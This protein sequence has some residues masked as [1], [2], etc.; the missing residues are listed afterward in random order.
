MERINGMQR[1]LS[2]IE[3]NLC[4]EIDYAKAAALAQTKEYHFQ[5]LFSML[6]GMTLG[7]YIRARRLTRAAADIR[8]GMKVID[9]AVKYGYNS[10]DSFSRAFARF[11][12]MPPGEARNLSVRL[13]SCLPLHI[14][15]T[16]KGGRLMDYRIEHRPEQKYLGFKR[17]FEG[18]PFGRDRE[19][20][21][22]ALFVST[23][24]YQWILRGLSDNDYNSDVVALADM[25]DDG[26][27]FWYCC[28]PD[29]Y[30]LEH[31]YDPAVTGI[32]FMERFGFETLDVPAGEYAVFSTPR[33]GRPVGD[34]VCL[35]EQIASEWLP[36]SG[37]TLRNAP[38]LA[39]YHWYGGGEK[40]KRYI[41]IFIPVEK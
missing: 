25:S 7:E 40:Q 14:K 24:A 9:V 13:N 2:Y 5:C 41:E 33:S 1:A 12:G 16:L 39:V 29:A 35:R 32:D 27:T 36:G 28:R 23:R 34:Y 17:H 4:E 10:P 19:L 22:E 38:E 11:H 30:S 20:Q 21:E 31:L 6:T 26:Y 8:K 18:A 3:E 15:L 37:Y